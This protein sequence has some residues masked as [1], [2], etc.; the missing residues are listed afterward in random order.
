MRWTSLISALLLSGAA[1]AT[2]RKVAQPGKRHVEH[3][4]AAKRARAAMAADLPELVA[5]ADKDHKFLN[6]N[7][8]SKYTTHRD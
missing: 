8:T 2:G 4:Q 3:E 6:A 5:R 1:D 7:T